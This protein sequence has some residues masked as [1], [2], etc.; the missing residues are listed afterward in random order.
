MKIIKYTAVAALSLLL[1]T[2]CFTKFDEYNTNPNQMEMWKINPASMIEMLLYS[3]A[4]GLLS[5]TYN[6]NGELIQYTVSSTTT[7]AYHRYEIPEGV[8]SSAWENLAQW[9]ANADHMIEL[10]K[11]KETKNF[12]AIGLTM[13]AL[14]MADL[15]SNFGDIPFTEAFKGR[16]QNIF[17]PKFDTQKQVF[18]QLLADLELA[19]S[20]YTA[21]EKMSDKEK[22]KD[23]LYAGDISK[24]QKF[25]NS[26]YLR[27]LMRVS[28]RNEE[29]GVSLKMKE[30]LA[31]P[32]KYPV[33]TDNADNAT[34][35]YTGI[36]PYDNYFGSQT[37]A[38]FGSR[39]MAE[40]FLNY[41]NETGD[42]RL[43]T[44]GVQSAGGNW[45]GKPSGMPTDESDSDGT[46]QLNKKVLGDY[47]SPYSFIKYDEVLFILS[48]AA[49]LGLIDG[50]EDV[51][52]GYYEA[53][54]TASL[55]Y[56]G[57]PRVNPGSTMTPDKISQ[58]I[59]KVP[60][61]N[62]QEC[63]VNQKYIAMFWVG[64]EAWHEYRRT[65]FPRLTIGTATMNDGILPT[66]FVYAINTRVT[67]NENYNKVVA[68]M[69]EDYPGGADNMRTPLWWSKEGVATEK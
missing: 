65:G 22:S 53:A 2:S 51:A 67:N 7:N 64:Y 69:A 42:P 39:R 21:A 38:A 10:A 55:N 48:E 63:I 31:N 45:L 24:W 29:L 19:N 8:T 52:K 16:D 34:L 59:E 62:T 58:F 41:M 50:G 57:S 44:F 25:T 32:V 49:H 30:I 56:W 26:L 13:R 47:T 1:G 43:P 18:T 15:A 37:A 33:F 60:F 3:G 11:K 40:Y 68:R 14:F 12:Q 5:R 61:V 54:I 17:K 35:F 27:L 4:E 28:N 23:L 46:A 36:T 6:I 9:S 20:L 66:R